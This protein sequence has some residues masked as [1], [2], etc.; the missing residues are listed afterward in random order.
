MSRSPRSFVAGIRTLNMERAVPDN[1]PARPAVPPPP[2]FL[3]TWL[4]VLAVLIL[5]AVDFHGDVRMR[6]AFSWMDPHQYYDFA[7]DFVTGERAYDG[8]ELPSIFP[9]CLYPLLKIDT[10]IQ[11]ALWINFAFACLMA[12]CV[13]G[14]CARLRIG[15]PPFIVLA[16]VLSSP[17]MIGLSRELYL[18]FSLSA[19][20]AL[21]FLIWF[22]TEG[23]T[24]AGYVLLFA[25]LF[26]IGV[27]MKMTYPLFFIAPFCVH[28]L[29]LLR[30][31]KLKGLALMAAAVAVPVAA[32]LLVEYLFFPLSFRYYS[33]LGNTSFPIMMM[34]GPVE[35]ASFESITYYF[36][37]IGKTLLF[38]AAPL[39]LLPIWKALRRGGTWEGGEAKT[40]WL[41]WAWFLGALILLI[42][43]PVKEP[44]HV[45]P[46]VLP[47]VLLIFR[48][49]GAVRPPSARLVL[50]GIVVLA[51]L[52]NYFAVTLKMRHF[53]YFMDGPVAA[54]RI[55]EE[56]LARDRSRTAALLRT[57]K[58]SPDHWKI[59]RNIV[60]GGFEP[61]EALAIAWHFHPAVV[62]DLDLLED[63][64]VVDS[65]LAFEGYED[66]YN[67]AVFNLYNRRCGWPVFYETIGEDAV[68]RN[69]DFAVLKN[70]TQKAVAERFD[71][72][73][74]AARIQSGGDEILILDTGRSGR[75]SYRV[76]FAE[77]IIK[78]NRELKPAELNAAYY[79]MFMT[80]VL[81][82][83]RVGVDSFLDR[84]PGGFR[85][86]LRIKNI[87]YY[88]SYRDMHGPLNPR[89]KQ[90][91]ARV[92]G[93]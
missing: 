89:F 74:L 72:F 11:T 24:R 52:G 86:D 70:Y 7:V 37:Q 22:K 39:L 18:E 3:R 68:V 13:I 14:L 10:G 65:S 40:G 62:Y 28:A 16:A 38:L 54:E 81:E 47:G 76:L 71:T 34:I 59:T 69:C 44:R 12:F 91:V 43:Q 50:I 80:Y 46:C 56:M 36:G 58:T 8:F 33:T 45:A 63:D 84:F 53:P 77:E 78:R 2:Q 20:V 87:Y 4:P 5:Y 51:A 21:Q 31:G 79:E 27:M 15:A 49:I 55:E 48:G 26:G 60:I 32:A 73:E 93:R 6:D 64:G 90:H 17:L 88:S 30:E 29:L 1:S 23:F 25:L 83:R 42:A 66:V 19:V 82:G 75:E 57:E 9:F 85:P 35:V 92:H 61:D 67:M 41:L